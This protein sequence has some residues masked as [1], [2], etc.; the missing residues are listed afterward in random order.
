LLEFY[1]CDAFYEGG[2]EETKPCKDKCGHTPCG[3]TRNSFYLTRG[4]NVLVVATT[5]AMFAL[6]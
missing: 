2:G 5:L 1:N 4:N 6:K 3:A